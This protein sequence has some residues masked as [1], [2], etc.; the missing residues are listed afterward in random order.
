QQGPVRLVK[1]GEALL[2]VHGTY[3]HGSAFVLGLLLVLGVLVRGFLRLV[4]QILVLL[5]LVAERQM[6]LPDRLAPDDE[7]NQATALK[8]VI[9]PALVAGAVRPE[10]LGVGGNPDRI[11]FAPR[12]FDNGR[13]TRASY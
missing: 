6:D 9:P 13:I 4:L 11:W 8:A 7:A 12:E 2:Y 3:P 10:V 1:N 5:R